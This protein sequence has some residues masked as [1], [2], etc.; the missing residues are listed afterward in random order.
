MVKK[1]GEL[2]LNLL[3]LVCLHLSTMVQPTGPWEEVAF[4]WFFGFFPLLRVNEMKCN[5]IY[6]LREGR[7]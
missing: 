1:K 3:H 2:I 5:M 7:K 4:L 6:V